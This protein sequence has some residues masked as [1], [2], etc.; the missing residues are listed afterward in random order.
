MPNMNEIELEERLSEPS[1]AAVEALKHLSGDLLLLGVNGKMGHSLARMARRALDA[2]GNKARVIGVARFQQGGEE[3]LKSY[4]IETQRCDLLN[5][6]DVERLPDAANV[7]FMTG[8]KFGSTGNEAATWAMN[9]FLPGVIC[10]RFSRS[11][12][13]AFS[14]GNV[15]GLT[16]PDCGGSKTTDPLI[17]VGEYAMSCVGRERMFEYFS[18]ELDIPTAII[19]LNYACDLRYGVLM[20]VLL[21]VW[22]EEPID[23]DMGYF[24]TIWQGD[25]N[26]MTLAAFGHLGSPPRVFNVTGPEILSVRTVCEHAAVRWNKTVRFVGTEAETALLNDPRASFDL[27]GTPRISGV[28]LIEWGMQWIESGGSSLNKPT[29]FESRTGKF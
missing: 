28:Q 20:D 6:L 3:Q 10:R 27:L 2:V 23:L 17:P 25:A 24:N 12:I 22:N 14:T 19:R 9:S 8:M 29:H 1:P 26:A 18:R 5:P 16:T 4:G 13:V 11:R 21:K 15:Y 7:L